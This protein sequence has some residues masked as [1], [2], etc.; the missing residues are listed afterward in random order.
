MDSKQRGQMPQRTQTDVGRD[1]IGEE[2]PAAAKV[3]SVYISEAEKSKLLVE[4][5][6]DNMDGLLIFSALFSMVVAA[7][8][9]ESYKTLKDIREADTRCANERSTMQVPVTTESF[10]PS[11]EAIL[12]NGLW[13]ISLGLSLACA[14]LA[15][16]VQQ[17]SQELLQRERVHSS[18]ISRFQMQTVVD[19]I[20][21]LL[22]TSMLI[23]FAGLVVFLMPLH[24]LTVFIAA[25]I[26]VAFTTAYA[27][28][29]LQP[30]WSSD[31]PY[32]TPLSGI[33]WTMLQVLKQVWYTYWSGDLT[34]NVTNKSALSLDLENLEDLPDYRSS[35]SGTDWTMVKAMTH[36][37]LE[38]SP[39]RDQKALVWTLKSLP[40]NGELQMFADALPDLLWGPHKRRYGYE[41]HIRHLVYNPQTRLHWR[42][43]GL[44]E[45]C[46]TDSLAANEIDRR[47]VTCYKALWTIASLAEPM[48]FRNSSVS[49]ELLSDYNIAVD[50]SAISHQLCQKS[51]NHE[52]DSLAF[53]SLSASTMMEWSTFHYIKAQLLQL[54]EDLN[55]HSSKGTNTNASDIHQAWL[56]VRAKHSLLHMDSLVS[57]YPESG[58]DEIAQ[59]CYHIDTLLNFPALI[60]AQ[61][62]TSSAA[63][64]SLPYHWDETWPM[65]AADLD[66]SAFP[67]EFDSCLD[68]LVNATMTT[69]RITVL[70]TIISALLSLWNPTDTTPIPN[71]MINLLKQCNS[72]LDLGG[73]LRSGRKI[74]MYLWAQFA[75]TLVHSWKGWNEELKL[76][77]LT[78]LWHLALLPGSPNVA[79]A[80]YLI[81]LQQTQKALWETLDISPDKHLSEITTSIILLLKFRIVSAQFVS[82][83]GTIADALACFRDPIFPVDTAITIPDKVLMANAERR[84]SAPYWLALYQSMACRKDEARIM[85]FAEF[86][87]RCTPDSFPYEAVE[88][89]G[90]IVIGPPKGPVHPNHQIRLANGVHATFVAHCVTGLLNAVINC[91]C[92]DLYAEQSNGKRDMADSDDRRPWFDN[93]G[94]RRR[95][96]ETFAEYAEK[97]KESTETPGVLTRLQSIQQGLS[98][99]H[100]EAEAARG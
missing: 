60:L 80:Q 35:S 21:L 12:C 10:R 8:F 69:P 38:A 79:P 78:A 9:T 41:D 24:Y 61:Y 33:I 100:A 3:W 95:L 65:I 4:S 16:F 82:D 67:Q 75:P 18:P 77:V 37:A 20:P 99:W 62:F 56:S 34:V 89:I 40:G 11:M 72:K 49:Q 55:S 53:Y 36:T 58:S 22:H 1:T 50:F 64:Q 96:Q 81:S 83:N 43:A 48:N 44:L 23:F 57:I 84:I 13:L 85:F 28:F 46:N 51:R 73:V 71:T 32:C 90:N 42:V 19:T 91:A 70:E 14:L 17:W 30:L 92:W 39:E 94:A 52:T 27:I 25:G 2:A 54:R 6:K 88:T 26:L 74:E 98:A 7:F 47:K 63:L 5:W 31:S 87:E 66:S 97:L 68:Y 29:T 93:P 59:L 15:T 76:K 86:L 45:S